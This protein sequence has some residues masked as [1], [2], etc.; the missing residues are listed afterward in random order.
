VRWFDL[1]ALEWLDWRAD[2]VTRVVA[3]ARRAVK[4]ADPDIQFS[5]APWAD[6]EHAY[7]YVGQDW[8]GW[9]DRGLVDIMCPMTYWGDAT[10]LTALAN[11]LRGRRRDARLYLGVGAF[12]HGA[13]YPATIAAGL[14]GAAVDGVILFDYGS[15]WRK[16]AI[17]PTL[18]E[19]C[20]RES[21][22]CE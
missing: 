14:E 4:N 18:A 12:N 22:T 1:H 13:S 5:A 7:R 8:L 2:Q 6:P 17:L 10:K 9:F 15:C 3:A 21:V 16:P 19:A 20:P 11:R